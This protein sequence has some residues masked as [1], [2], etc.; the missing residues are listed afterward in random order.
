MKNKQSHKKCNLPEYE[1]QAPPLG[2]FS[3]CL[4][5]KDRLGTPVSLQLVGRLIDIEYGV[6]LPWPLTNNVKRQ[7]KTYAPI[8][9]RL[10]F[11]RTAKK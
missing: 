11:Q 8:Y 7:N 9:T 6:L 1:P 5:F 4:Y 3:I 10:C 2:S